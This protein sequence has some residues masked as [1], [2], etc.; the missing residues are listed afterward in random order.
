MVV[1]SLSNTYQAQRAPNGENAVF[2]F[3]SLFRISSEAQAKQ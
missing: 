2:L 1:T 3:A